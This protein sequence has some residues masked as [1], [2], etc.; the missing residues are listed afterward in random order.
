[1]DLFLY[2]ADSL[3]TWHRWFQSCGIRDAPQKRQH[4]LLLEQQFPSANGPRERKSQNCRKQNH[5]IPDK[6]TQP[7]GSFQRFVVQS[8]NI[9]AS[10]CKVRKADS[11]KK[12]MTSWILTSGFI[13]LQSKNI[14]HVT[15][16]K[17]LNFW[18]WS[19]QHPTWTPTPLDA[20][21]SS[22]CVDSRFTSVFPPRPAYKRSLKTDIFRSKKKND[23]HSLIMV[24]IGKK[25]GLEPIKMKTFVMVVV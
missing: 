1:M 8:T 3:T 23:A 20:S 12:N 19:C 14:W 6:N 11:R 24:M 22:A 10:T 13:C 5:Q 25:C 4:S 17:Y 16:T 9:N 21:W 7:V 15:Y 18:G 2:Q